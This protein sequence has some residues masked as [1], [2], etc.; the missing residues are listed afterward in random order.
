MSAATIE[1]TAPTRAASKYFYVWL[2]ALC[3]FIAFAG[4]APTFWLPV[5]RHTLKADPI[6]YIH[7]VA[8]AGWTLF[9][10]NQARLAASAHMRRHRALGMVGISF[11][12][13]IVMLGLLIAMNSIR[14]APPEY[15]RRALAFSIWSLSAILYFAGAVTVALANTHRPEIHKRLLLTAT[16][17]ALQGAVERWFLVFGPLSAPGPLPI[18]AANAPAL[19]IDVILLGLMVHDWRTR[20]RVQPTYLIAVSIIAALQ[21]LMAPA[22]KTDAWL[23]FAEWFSRL[24]G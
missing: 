12:T 3:V 19:V 1:G 7:G 16:L 17:F 6:V 20:G 21:F 24:A 2:A 4:F 13:I 5:A 8:M 22:S 15:Y 18:E 14:A 23:A 10:F 9:L 11:A